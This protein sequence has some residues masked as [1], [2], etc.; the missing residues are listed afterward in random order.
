MHPKIGVGAFR[1]PDGS[2]RSNS[3][4]M[5]SRERPGLVRLTTAKSDRLSRRNAVVYWVAI[6]ALMALGLYVRREALWA[7][8][9]ADDYAQLAMLDGTYPLARAPYN[10]FS[11]SDGTTSEGFRLIRAGF[12]PWW[13]DP[14]VRLVMLRPLA[15][16]M[17][18]LDHRLFGNDAFLFHLHSAAWW[19]V[20]LG[21]IAAFFRKMLSPAVALVAF[22]L[23]AFD[24][25]HSGALTWIC[26]RAAFI[27]IAFSI[28]ALYRYVEH[29]RAGRSTWP[30]AALVLYAIAFGFGEYAIC[31]VAY[32]LAYEL[33]ESH[34]PF[35]ARLRAVAPML[36]PAIVFLCVRGVVGAT[37]RRSGVYVDPIGEPV[38][39][40]K[41]VATRLPVFV[42]DLAL[43]VPSAYWTFGMP[44]T[45]AW[46]SLGWVPVRW[47][48]DP[49]PWRMVQFCIGL[50]G[51]AL[52]ALVAHYTLRR[53]PTPNVGWLLV[54]SLLSLVPVCG[55]YPSS[56]LLL[57]SLPGFTP[58]VAAFVVKGAEALRHQLRKRPFY[59]L[60]AG[61]AAVG[62]ATY[63]IVM[64][65]FWQRVEL[66]G[67]LDGSTRVRE[68]ILHMPV[69]DAA[70]PNQDLVLLT[71][72][73]G[74]TSMYLPLT[75]LR[76]GKSAPRSCLFLSYLIAPYDLV[77]LNTSSF[78]IRFRGT[79]ALLG[80]ASEQLLRSPHH[81]FHKND[82]IDVGR[83]RITVLDLYEDK[84]QY[85][86]IDFDRPLEAPSLLFMALTPD[87]YRPVYLPP[88]GEKLVIL[89]AAL[90]KLPE[91][92]PAG[93]SS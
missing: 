89:P 78:T 41:A 6:A 60:T 20:M 11:F 7:G 23:L 53:R 85:L 22:A 34:G 13:A 19:F 28:A 73:E 52:L 70:F 46:A 61:A 67:M 4:A 91:G 2:G 76:Y 36:A 32:F 93:H 44:W 87:G 40:F 82:I 48:H 77:R 33:C 63:Q 3:S 92:P 58:L 8:F 30:V 64:S 26:N 5:A 74:A 24:E 25:A 10:L 79:D 81:P 72:L 12:Y 88:V 54:G 59:A 43:A 66:T 27:S 56:R 14:Q 31:L 50:G 83:W 69:D 35:K 42:G 86:R 16:L 47:V 75:R 29:R 17:I 51:T 84:P 71:S 1:R 90:P 57:A 49:E 15:S 39:F 37:V 9:V 38:E 62:V 55:S 80:T 65:I 21:V 68:A 18:A 45:Y